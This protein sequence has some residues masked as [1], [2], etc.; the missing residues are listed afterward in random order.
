MYN[1]VAKLL[2]PPPSA[3]PL[4]L[5]ANP[6]LVIQQI[7]SGQLTEDTINAENID[8]WHLLLLL[9]KHS[10][11]QFAV[12]YTYKDTATSTSTQKSSNP[13]KQHV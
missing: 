8:G 11:Q 10:S 7:H 12:Q 5:V 6:Q 13:V 1:K 4:A 9:G 2:Q 3:V